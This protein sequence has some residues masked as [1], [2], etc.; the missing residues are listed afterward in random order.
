MKSSHQIRNCQQNVGRFL[1]AIAQRNTK[2]LS[3]QAH[4]RLMPTNII[5]VAIVICRGPLIVIDFVEIFFP[6]FFKTYS[7]CCT[8]NS[9]FLF[10]PLL[11]DWTL[12]EIASNWILLY[13]LKVKLKSIKCIDLAL[14]GGKYSWNQ[15]Q[16]SCKKKITLQI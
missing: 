16:I 10:V 3:F 1:Y 11:R 13:L 7:I 4:Y 6:A 12:L 14:F 9:R 2:W 15:K 8:T 5:Y